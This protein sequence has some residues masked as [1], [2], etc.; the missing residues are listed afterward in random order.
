MKRT[1]EKYNENDMVDNTRIANLIKN[2][3]TAKNKKMPLAM[4]VIAPENTLIPIPVNAS[5]ILLN[6]SSY[7][8][9]T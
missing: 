3:I 6:L 7:G 8:H 9:S 2:S 1:K 5:C 4:V